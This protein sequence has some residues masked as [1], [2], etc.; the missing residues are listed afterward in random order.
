MQQVAI[1][2]FEDLGE[3][4]RWI[5]ATERLHDELRVP[6]GDL[7]LLGQLDGEP[8]EKIARSGDEGEGRKGNRRSCVER[9]LEEGVL[10]IPMSK[11]AISLGSNRTSTSFSSSKHKQ[12]VKASDWR[13]TGSKPHWR[14]FLRSHKR[15][16]RC[17][18]GF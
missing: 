1:H 17:P 11:N 9:S 2:P 18:E 4:E 6:S 15:D 8:S 12:A 5:E 3:G 7:D 16:T 13:R 14:A 10:A